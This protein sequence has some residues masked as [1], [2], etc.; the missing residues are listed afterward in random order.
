[1]K[2][3]IKNVCVRILCE[4]PYK[5]VFLPKAPCFML[6]VNHIELRKT[7]ESKENNQEAKSFTKN[8]NYELK[9]FGV[10]AHMMDN[11]FLETVILVFLPNILG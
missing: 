2:I 10:T 8:Q 9:I 3:K 11:Y 5:N 4:K 6:K 7:F 1:M